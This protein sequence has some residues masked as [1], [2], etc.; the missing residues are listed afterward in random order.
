MNGN[1]FETILYDLQQIFKE[2]DFAKKHFLCYKFLLGW[3]ES[4]SCTFAFFVKF[5]EKTSQQ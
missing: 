1:G 3:V 5:L 4:A 2:L